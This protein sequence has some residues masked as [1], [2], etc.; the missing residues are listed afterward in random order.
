M[1]SRI[2]NVCAHCTQ[3]FLPRPEFLFTQVLY[4]PHVKPFTAD[5]VIWEN[6]PL[7]LYYSTKQII[8]CFLT[9]NIKEECFDKTVCKTLFSIYY[10]I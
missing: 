10:F 6:K 3:S 2:S 7:N 4:F 5:K 8:F 1:Q 9:S